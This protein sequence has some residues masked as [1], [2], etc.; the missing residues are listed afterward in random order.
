MLFQ[1]PFQ[2]IV[3]Y[4]FS[5]LSIYWR[6]KTKLFKNKRRMPNQALPSSPEGMPLAKTEG[7]KKRTS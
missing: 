3:E 7:C 5:Y 6:I 4:S 2:I 1:N